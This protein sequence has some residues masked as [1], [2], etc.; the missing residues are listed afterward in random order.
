M[1]YE[2]RRPDFGDERRRRRDLRRESGVVTVEDVE[3]SEA[4]FRE[5]LRRA[6]VMSTEDMLSFGVGR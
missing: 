2:R 3:D 4:P 1:A 6:G 5:L